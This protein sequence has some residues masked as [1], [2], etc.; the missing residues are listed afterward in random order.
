MYNA[1]TLN[2]LSLY[3]LVD[4]DTWLTTIILEELLYDGPQYTLQQHA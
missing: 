3:D 4:F 1:I 2:A